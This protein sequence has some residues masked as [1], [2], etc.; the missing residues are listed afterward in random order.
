MSVTWVLQKNL[1]NAVDFDALMRACRE[2]GHEPVG[3]RVVP[4]SDE[5]P[6]IPDDRPVVFYGGARWTSLV[7]A[8]GRWSPGVFWDDDAFKMT[9]YARAWGDAM[10][11]HG[12]WGSVAQVA[13]GEAMLA[14]ATDYFVRPERD[15][16]SFAGQ[17]LTGAALRGWCERLVG[18][19]TLIEE[20]TLILVAPTRAIEREWRLFIVDGEVVASTGYRESGRLAVTPGA[21]ARVIDFA[22]ELCAVHQPSRAFVMDVA[23]SGGELKIIE[24]NGLN[25]SGFYAASIPAIVER[26]SALA[27][28]L[29]AARVSG[30]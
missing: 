27:S 30:C 3:A 15:I 23:A 2:L 24:A 21:P 22:H 8:R 19:D 18:V 11:N 12:W 7:A 4:F 10:L 20:D 9:T 16:K 14:P 1:I 13:A 5:L 28:E 29:W 6:E 17:V 25:S 26:V